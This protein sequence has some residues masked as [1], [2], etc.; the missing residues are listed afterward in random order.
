MKDAD[1][2]TL[3]AMVEAE[4]QQSFQDDRDE[5]RKMTR[6]GIQAIQ[7][8]NRRSYN[9]R[10]RPA[11]KYEKGDLVALP[12]TQFGPGI[13]YRQ[14]F[15]DPYV[16]KEILEHDRLS[17]RKLDDDAEGPSQTTTACS[18]VKP[19]VHPGRM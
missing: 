1:G 16:V 10:K 15:Y 3:R 12:V 13:K 5:L 19:W 18:A 9:L 7:D 8:E 14:R 4:L 2:N 6:D 17:L 11:R